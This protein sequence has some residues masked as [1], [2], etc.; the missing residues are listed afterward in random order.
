MYGRAEDGQWGR[1]MGGQSEREKKRWGIR[2]VG[3]WLGPE[4]KN[5]KSEGGGR[6]PPRIGE[7]LLM[8]V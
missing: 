5:Y 2:K 4:F 6:K 8:E 1:E 3:G 7:S